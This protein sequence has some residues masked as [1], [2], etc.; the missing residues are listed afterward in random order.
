MDNSMFKI[1]DFVLSDEEPERSNEIDYQAEMDR[2]SE[3]QEVFNDFTCY[4]CMSARVD[5]YIDSCQHPMCKEC[6][7]EYFKTSGKKS[8]DFGNKKVARCPMC[9]MPLVKE[10]MRKFRILR[11]L[12]ENSKMECEYKQ[13]GCLWKGKVKHYHSFHYERCRFGKFGCHYVNCQFEGHFQAVKDHMETCRHQILDCEWCEE[14][15]IYDE[16]NDHVASCCPGP[17]FAEL[18]GD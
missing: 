9:W 17:L 3:E 5:C 8:G 4:I 11:T 7:D 1:E 13:E 6:M 10:R 15:M 14:A 18:G 2:I 16:F 12:I